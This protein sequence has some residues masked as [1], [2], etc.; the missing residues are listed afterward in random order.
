MRALDDAETQNAI[1]AHGLD[2][3]TGIGFAFLGAA[4]NVLYDWHA[5]DY[6]QLMYAAGGAAQI[7]TDRGRHILPQGRA[8]W[9]PAGTRHRSLITDGGGASLYFSPEAVEDR[10]R[11]VRIVVASPLMREMI[12]FATR[13]PLGASETDPLAD[14][15]LRALALLCGEW[16]LCELPLFLPSAAHPSIHRAMDYALAD[17]AAATLTE[18]LRH[19]A[20]SERTFRRLFARETGLTWQN[21]LGQARIQMAMGLLDAGSKNNRRRG[22][23]RLC[24]PQRLRKGVCAD[25]R[26]RAGSIPA[27]SRPRDELTTPPGRCRE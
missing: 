10:S 3:P 2:R 13:W 12:L 15:F 23:C 7:E 6:H 17:L 19:A 4:C 26:R 21:W 1:R 20:L 18:A 22:R 9:I 11:H 14:N 5:H 25:R 27:A 8:V 24:V 16:L